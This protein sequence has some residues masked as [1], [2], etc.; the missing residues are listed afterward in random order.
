MT[1]AKTALLAVLAP[2][3]A[4]TAALFATFDAPGLRRE[5]E[6]RVRSTGMRF[7]VSRTRYGL[8]RGLLLEGVRA[9]AGGYDL[10]IPRMALEHRLLGLLRGRRDLTGI[11]VDEVRIGAVSIESLDLSLARFDYDT[12]ALTPLHGIDISG[13]LGVKRV[14]FETWDLL[15]LSASLVA[16][17]GRFRFDTLRAATGRGELA[18]D[19]ALDF[20][21]LPFRYRGSLLG[22][23]FSVGGLGPGTLRLKV[24][25]FGAR[26]RNLKGSGTFELE[27]GRLPD[28]SW[29]REIDPSLAGAEHARVEIPFEIRDERVYID[30]V[31]IEAAGKV[32]AVEGSLGLDGSRNLFVH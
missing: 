30:R 7:E 1:K 10:H 17:G 11:R 23:A 5:V 32:I 29:I 18:G 22:P 20:N 26:L 13:A 27:R 6:E 31:P 14:L 16:E 19:L 28:S 3:A 12:R 24:E 15:D 2:L 21:S 8:L 25:G 4:L 9:T